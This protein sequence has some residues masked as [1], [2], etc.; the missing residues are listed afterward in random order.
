MINLDGVVNSWKF[1]ED[2][3]YHLCSY[4]DQEK[5]SYLLDVFQGDRVLTAVPLYPYY[6]DCTH[7]LEL[8]WQADQYSPDWSL[9][10]FRIMPADE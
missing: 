3:Q 5:I 2:D 9:K 7:R 1:F 4:W 10:A 6:K 8:I